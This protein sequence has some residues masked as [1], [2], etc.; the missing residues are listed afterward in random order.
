[1]NSASIRS[2][3]AVAMLLLVAG[4][5]LPT[6]RAPGPRVW[7]D[8]PLDGAYLPLAPVVVQ[9]HASWEGG[10]ASAALL[11]NGAQVRVDNAPDA[12]DP[13]AAFAQ[14]WEPTEVGDYTLQVVATDKGGNSGRSNPV[15]VHVGAE[16]VSTV[17]VDSSAPG[18]PVFEPP[19]TLTPASQVVITVA[20]PTVPGLGPKF[21]FTINGNC[22]QGP[23]TAYPVITSFF[24]GDQV[25]MA[26]RNEDASWYWL[27]IPNGNS[28]CAAAASTG[29]T[30]GPTDNLPFI[31]APPPPA[32]TVA[33]PTVVVVTTVAPPPA[34]GKPTV[35]T[36]SCTAS[37]YVVTLQWA[38]VKGEQGYRVYRDDKLIDTL[39]ADSTVYDDASP[40]Y[41]AH[42]YRIEAFNGTGSASSPAQ[43]SAGCLY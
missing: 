31:P 23:G 18:L 20:P 7:I 17:T 10:T 5:S 21:Q 42:S 36:K 24:A 16:F 28:Q 41:N 30:L 15:L 34:P 9:S 3:G 27:S 25:P 1:M 38:N 4:C 19:P 2:L 40:D 13:L 14:P 22:R 29:I 43:N 37:E 33:P 8:D 6:G 32:T 12:S 35:S 39:P 26:G 11:V